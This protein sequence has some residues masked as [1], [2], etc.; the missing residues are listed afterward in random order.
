MDFTILHYD[1]F[2]ISIF[3]DTRLNKP[4]DHHQYL[5]FSELNK[6]EQNS[7]ELFVIKVKFMKVDYFRHDQKFK[8]L[9]RAR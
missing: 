7:I 5:T 1:L 4:S 3:R 2:G 9:I 6:I 8:D